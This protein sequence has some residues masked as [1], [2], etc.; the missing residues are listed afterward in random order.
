MRMPPSDSIEAA[1]ALAEDVAANIR[2]QHGALAP[3]YQAAEDAARAYQAAWGD[4]DQVVPATDEIGLGFAR[5]SLPEGRA[6]VRAYAEALAE[7]LCNS[8]GSLHKKVKEAANISVTSLIGWFLTTLG[9]G[10]AAAC[11]LAPIAGAVAALGLVAFCRVC[12]E[13]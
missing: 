8:S 10:T 1:A 9:L 7:D 5:G 2:N 12:R 11:L 3:A 13:M 6:I 4:L